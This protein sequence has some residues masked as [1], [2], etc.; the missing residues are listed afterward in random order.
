MD[1]HSRFEH[2][3]PFYRMNINDFEGKVKRYISHGQTVN[4]N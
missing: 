2:S 4:F 1:K 3:L